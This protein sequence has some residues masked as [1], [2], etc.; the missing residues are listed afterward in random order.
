MI[1]KDLKALTKLLKSNNLLTINNQII[2]EVDKVTVKGKA[3]SYNKQQDIVRELN[4]TKDEVKIIDLDSEIYHIVYKNSVLYI[5]KIADN[6]NLDINFVTKVEKSKAGII[7]TNNY[8]QF[9]NRH[10]T[11][12]D[13]FLKET[14]FQECSSFQDALIS[15]KS[16][17]IKDFDFTDHSYESINDLIRQGKIIVIPINKF[18]VYDIINAFTSKIPEYYKVN[19]IGNFIGCFQYYIM[20]IS[21]EIV[22]DYAVGMSSLKND[23]LKD[24]FTQTTIDIAKVAFEDELNT[25]VNYSA[26]D[27]TQEKLN[28]ILTEGVAKGA[29][30]ISF[31]S[32]SKPMVRLHKVLIPLENNIT[33]TPE[34]LYNYS[35]I[36]LKTDESKDI[37]A[38]NKQ[39]DYAYSIKNVG[40]FRVSIYKQ[41]NTVALSFRYIPEKA[42]SADKAGIPKQVIKLFDTGKNDIEDKKSPRSFKDGL[43]IVAGPVNT[44]KST[45]MNS[46][47][48]HINTIKE[49]KIMTVEDPI[50][51]IHK[52]KKSLIEQRE[53]GIDCN[54]FEDGLKQALRSDPDVISVGEMRTLEAADTIL[55]VARSGHVALST[56]HTPTVVQTL[57]SILHMFPEASR[58]LVRAMLAESLRMVYCQKLLP[59]KS[60]GLIVA[61]EILLN[62]EDVRAILIKPTEPLSKLNNSMTVGVNIGMISMD[63]SI[64]NLYTQGLITLEV[65]KANAVDLSMLK[66]FIDINDKSK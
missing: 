39:A 3:F 58:D 5:T 65:A 54:S 56:F 46:F 44:G 30:D 26:Y 53:I 45:T 49:Y 43:I 20:P 31:S 41:N 32:G 42:W 37:F 27:M 19:I 48:D 4:L 52:S 51:V 34:I 38:T 14:E 13:D 12:L 11:K 8:Q 7:L 61:Q 36:V 28:E 17:I 66:S 16:V 24:R 57:Q 62:T 10:I 18:S 21:R 55:K 35:Q 9:E 33:L 40:R 64:A 23:I 1:L 29:S 59:K 6:I 2:V 15:P 25:G 47:I 50:E 63:R 60:G 22:K